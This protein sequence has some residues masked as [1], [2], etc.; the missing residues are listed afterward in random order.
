MKQ[1]ISSLIDKI[2]QLPPDWHG[3]GSVS[4]S[5]LRRIAAH[6]EK[7]GPIHY[8]MET[9][10]GKTTLLFSHL[11]SHHLVFS[12]DA[13][14]SI[15]QVRGCELFNAQTTSFVEGPS[16][17]TLP[18]HRFEHPVQIALIDGPHAYPFPDLEYYYFYPLIDKGGLLLVDDVDIPSIRR[19]FEIIRADDMFELQEMVDV[20]G[21]MAIFKRTEMPLLDPTGDDWWLQGFNRRHYAG[22]RPLSNKGLVGLLQRLTPNSVRSMVPLRL[23]K[24]L[25]LID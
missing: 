25:R 1:E 19:M 24:L 18:Q 15:S 17:T 5:A 4:D 21:K 20:G 7:L 22:I 8:S 9:G 12:V 13:G 3:C 10:S 16:Q 2:A 14:G 23:K 11:S 6:A